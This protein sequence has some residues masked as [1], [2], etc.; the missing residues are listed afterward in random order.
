MLCG[1]T[2]NEAKSEF[3]KKN[4]N[5]MYSGSGKV[6]SQDVPEGTKIEQGSIITIKLE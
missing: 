1:K 2:L 4:L 6:T 3:S 5:V